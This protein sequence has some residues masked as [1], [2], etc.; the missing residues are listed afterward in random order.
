MSDVGDESASASDTV[1][2]LLAELEELEAAVDDP[3]EREEVQ[4]TIR[5]IDRLPGGSAGRDLI[6]KFTKRDIAEAF[7]GSILISLPLLV[8]D[9][10][11]D[12]AEVFLAVPVL[13]VLNIV[14]VIG[15]VAGLLYFAD[16]R[17]IRVQRPLF[18]VI[19][20]R[21]LAVLVIAFITAT[22]TMTLWGRV[23]NWADPSV[24]LARISV[25]WTVSVFGAALGDIL[26]G[27]SAAADI[28][29]EIDHLGERIGIGDE[30]GWW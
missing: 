23:D 8:E 22:F 10:V 26:P 24:A 16:F 7:V 27:E 19:P 20:R 28:N 18:G 1:D 4:E 17:D 5:L 13:F 29:D 15:M 12:I 30:E 3:A 14:F 2:D 6:R 25:V 21:F 9:G 11:F